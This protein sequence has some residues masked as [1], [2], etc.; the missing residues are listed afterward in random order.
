M[1]SC[2]HT[3]Q[4]ARKFQSVHEPMVKLQ[5]M[6]CHRALGSGIPLSGFSP[7][8]QQL[9]PPALKGSAPGSRKRD[10]RD[11]YKSRDWRD[12]RRR[13]LERDGMECRSCENPATEV[14]HMSY[15]EPVRNT[16]DQ[17]LIS[18]CEDCHKRAGE[19]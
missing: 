6:R 3:E 16:P 2:P 1:S 10:L 9:I 8:L 4:M 14:H 7:D 15:Y 18:L 13:V 5:C 12:Q 11:F 19:S 17:Y